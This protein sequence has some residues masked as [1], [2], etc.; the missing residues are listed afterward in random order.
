MPEATNVP[1]PVGFNLNIINDKLNMQVI[2]RSSDLAVGLVYDTISFRMLNNILA[3]TLGIKTGDMEF[4]LLNAH[5]Y[6]TQRARVASLVSSNALSKATC[7]DSANDY[8]MQDVVNNPS[9]FIDDYVK[10]QD[11]IKEKPMEMPVAI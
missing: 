6:G 2:M 1:C 5:I 9:T 11:N 8:T 3:N 4:V 7:I 10:L